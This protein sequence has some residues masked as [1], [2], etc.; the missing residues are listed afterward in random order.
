M[1]TTLQNPP[2]RFLK[3]N[4]NSESDH[5][6]GHGDWECLTLEEAKKKTGQALREDAPKIRKM[7]VIHQFANT[8]HQQLANLNAANGLRPHHQHH[9]APG[10]DGFRS[11]NLNDRERMVDAI[12]NVDFSN[13]NPGAGAGTIDCN[14]RGSPRSASPNNSNTNIRIHSPPYPSI[15]SPNCSQDGAKEQYRNLTYGN[16]NHYSNKNYPA[17]PPLLPSP[18][19]EEEYDYSTNANIRYAHQTGGVQGAGAG[20]SFQRRP[21]SHNSYAGYSPNHSYPPTPT[22]APASAADVRDLSDF[23]LI[24]IAMATMPKNCNRVSSRYHHRYGNAMGGETGTRKRSFSSAH[25]NSVKKM[26]I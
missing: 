8:N 17:M 21:Y 2:G 7:N 20:T 15:V 11:D 25:N 5:G 19:F 14:G 13:T 1:V 23:E 6:H 18:S 16:S 24:Q 4:F 26:R 22:P 10:M 12:R 9:V 3:K